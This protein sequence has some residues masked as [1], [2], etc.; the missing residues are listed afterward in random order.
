MDGWTLNEGLEGEGIN[1]WMGFVG[2]ME[3]QVNRMY[4][5][6]EERKFGERMKKKKKKEKKKKEKKE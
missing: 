5:H 3:R 4:V 6:V 2:G 1:G